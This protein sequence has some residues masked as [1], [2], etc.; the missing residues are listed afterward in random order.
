MAWRAHACNKCQLRRS[1]PLPTGWNQAGAILEPL[2]L[3]NQ[4]I[5]LV[6]TYLQGLLSRSIYVRQGVRADLVF[7]LTGFSESCHSGKWFKRILSQIPNPIEIESYPRFIPSLLLVRLLNLVEHE[8]EFGT[9][10]FIDSDP[11]CSS[12]HTTC[13]AYVYKTSLSKY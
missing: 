9:L 1:T 10:S 6:C 4:E 3:N 5:P 12:R 11:L 2:D 13:I 8:V 7:R